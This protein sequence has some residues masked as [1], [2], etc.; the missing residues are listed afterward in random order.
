MR[1]VITEKK[2]DV[3]NNQKFN[4]YPNLRDKSEDLPENDTV[5]GILTAEGCE[6]FLKY[7]PF[8]I[9]FENCFPDNRNLIYHETGISY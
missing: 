2:L 7:I 3:L 5:S 1:H 8:N 6:I 9:N 4:A